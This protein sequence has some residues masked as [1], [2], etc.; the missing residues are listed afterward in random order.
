MHRERDSFL[1]VFEA[2]PGK[3]LLAM[4]AIFVAVFLL[5]YFLIR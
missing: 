5:V 4:V 2:K 1:Q 3:S